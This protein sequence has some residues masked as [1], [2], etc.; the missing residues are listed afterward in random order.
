MITASLARAFERSMR[1]SGGIWLWA[2]GMCINQD[3]VAERSQQVTLMGEIYTRASK[4]LAHLPYSQQGENESGAWSATSLMNLLNRVWSRELDYSA[5]S[6]EEWEKLLSTAQN[7]INLWKTSLHFWMIPWFTRSWIL[8]EG[9][10][11]DTVVVFFG[12]ATCSLN[13]ITMFWDLAR[14]RDL[15]R[16]LKYGPLADV[17]MTSR[18]LSQ[19]SSLKQVRAWLHKP[20]ETGQTPKSVEHEVKSI[21]DDDVSR[22]QQNSNLNLLN[23]LALSRPNGA[24][25]PRDKVYALLAI[26]QDDIAKSIK[27]DYSIEN[28][29]AKV[30]IEVAEKYIKHGRGPELLHHA[31]GNHLVAD[32]PSWVPD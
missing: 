9:I 10:L 5:K 28:T 14:R 15:P 25:D 24:T 26:V 8:Q 17:Y 3:D 1:W 18:N 27:P 6:E 23:L 21:Q 4:V 7:S 30:Y 16:I 2:D 12:N 29:V 13:A 32:L 22:P 19:I 11:G 31:G 20:S